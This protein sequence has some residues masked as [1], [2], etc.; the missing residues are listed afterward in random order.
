MS[1]IMKEHRNISI[2]DQIFEQLERDILSGKYQ[3]GELLSEVR[4]AKELEVSRTPIREALLRLEQENLLVESGRGMAVLGIS[5]EDMIDMYDIRMRLEGE[6]GRRAAL[7]ITDDQLSELQELVELQRYYIEK[8]GNSS[9]EHTKNLDSQFHELLY[10]SSGSTVYA[11]VLCGLHKKMTKYRMASVSKQSRA[12]QSNNEHMAIYQA[13]A[14]HDPEK[15]A[16]AVLQHA[17]QALERMESLES[18]TN[19]T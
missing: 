11:D 18:V 14:A 2:A 6:V 1:V 8:Q 13:L 17:K 19:L 5:R 10:R 16:E 3:R 4:L 15:T 9:S 12:L 7:N